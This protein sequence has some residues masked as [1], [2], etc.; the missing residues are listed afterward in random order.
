ML[1]VF[2]RPK[3]CKI[4]TVLR[5]GETSWHLSKLAKATDTT[6]VYVT[7]L[8]TRL[9]LQGIVTIS[10]KGKKRIVKL[11][12]KGMQIANSIEELRKRLEDKTS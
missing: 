5:D 9:E 3:P 4:M 12:D 11:T 7:A 1:Q 6:Y 2:V 8:M 10:S